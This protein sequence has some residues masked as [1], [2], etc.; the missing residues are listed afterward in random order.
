M[1]PEEGGRAAAD[2][3][4]WAIELAAAL[5]LNAL[6]VLDALDRTQIRLQRDRGGAPA[7]A[8]DLIRPQPVPV[9]EPKRKRKG[10]TA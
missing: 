2:Q 10:R 5:N 4:A 1:T 6:T 3:A 7:L 9:T 8:A